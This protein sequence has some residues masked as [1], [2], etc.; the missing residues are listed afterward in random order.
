MGRVASIGGGWE[1]GATDEGAS[2]WGMEWQAL[3]PHGEVPTGLQA[4]EPREIL[5]RVA[6]A[7]RRVRDRVDLRAAHGHFP[8]E[9]LARTLALAIAV[10]SLFMAAVRSRAASTTRAI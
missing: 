2:A 9:P 8:F 7:S 3:G 4:L 1:K 6:T 10:A 5:E